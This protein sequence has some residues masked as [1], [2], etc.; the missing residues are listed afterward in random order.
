[1]PGEVV[2]RQ[3]SLGR[4]RRGLVDVLHAEA[5]HGWWKDAVERDDGWRIGWVLGWQGFDGDRT[6]ILDEVAAAHEPHPKPGR[7]HAELLLR[8]QV[9]RHSKPNLAS[10]KEFGVDAP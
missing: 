8:R 3:A 5:A 7:V 4:L 2:V 6:S 9:H 10:K 1:L